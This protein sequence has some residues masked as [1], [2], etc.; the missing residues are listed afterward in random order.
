MD[1]NLNVNVKNILLLNRLEASIQFSLILWQ[2]FVSNKSIW[3]R[4]IRSITNERKFEYVRTF[5]ESR[6]I[7]NAVC[8][9]Q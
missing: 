7:N 9:T 6:A 5:A 2:L 4:I 3:M 1:L 8:W